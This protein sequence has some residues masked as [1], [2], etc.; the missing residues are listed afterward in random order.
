[1]NHKNMLLKR[2]FC[3]KILCALLSLNVVS[4]MAA[5]LLCVDTGPVNGVQP[6]LIPG[7]SVT[8]VDPTS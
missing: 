1:M 4:I 2:L 6:V 7:I 8:V 5:Y 3:L